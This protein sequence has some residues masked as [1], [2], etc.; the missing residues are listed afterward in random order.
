MA[1]TYHAGHIAAAAAESKTQFWAWV[2][3]CFHHAK[4]KACLMK[5]AGV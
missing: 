2:S 5:D 1:W 4:V 3:A